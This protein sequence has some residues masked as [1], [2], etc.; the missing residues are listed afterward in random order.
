M[1]TSAIITADIVNSTLLPAKQEKKLRDTLR[2]ILKSYKY[3]FY[4]GDSFQVYVKE[5]ENAL[6]LLLQLRLAAKK[7][8]V[9]E[10]D[11]LLSDIRASIGIGTVDVVQQLRTAS[12]EAFILSG[13]A[14]DEMA[15]SGARMVMQS[16][17]IKLNAGLKVIA[18]F[19]DYIFQRLTQKQVYVVSELLS[20]LTQEDIARKLKKTQPT[21]YKHSQ[22]SGWSQIVEL[23][24]EYQKIINLL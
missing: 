20:G 23:M 2:T 19:I 24:K 1:I 5:P 8:T 3:E 16:P 15:D 11:T 21:I 7:M 12:G 17:D 9:S 6:R 18:G 22:A 10:S 14:F 13:R 4:R